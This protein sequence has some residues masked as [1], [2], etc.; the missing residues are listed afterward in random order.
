MYIEPFYM[1][2]TQSL[3]V[4]AYNDSRILAWQTYHN[5]YKMSQERAGETS[6]HEETLWTVPKKQ[7]QNEIHVPIK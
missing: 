2:L 3:L 7:K 1:T 5:T 6:T 4:F